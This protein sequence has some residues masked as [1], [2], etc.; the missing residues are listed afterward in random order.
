MTD[1][2]RPRAARCR[3]RLPARAQGRR[4]RRRRFPPGSRT[5]L[6]SPSGAAACADALAAEPGARQQQRARS[7]AH[8]LP[9]RMTRGGPRACRDSR[10]VVDSEL[11][12]AAGSSVS[13][14]PAPRPAPT[15]RCLLI[16]CAALSTRHPADV[17]MCRYAVSC[18][19]LSPCPRDR[20]GTPPCPVPVPRC[21]APGMELGGAPTRRPGALCGHAADRVGGIAGGQVAVYTGQA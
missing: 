10:W 16:P 9:D 20:S 7:G 3:A 2:G 15:Y 6:M 5:S 21:A 13:Y 19:P 14:R 4:G 1:P 18:L 17:H 8:P 11:F 12:H